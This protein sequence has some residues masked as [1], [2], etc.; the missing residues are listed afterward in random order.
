PVTPQEVIDA[1]AATNEASSRYARAL[2][3]GLGYILGASK[4][5][6]GTITV[7]EAKSRFDV[8]V[9]ELTLAYTGPSA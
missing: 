9:P 3:K 6:E 8:G 7:E 5:F 4:L 2:V 1:F